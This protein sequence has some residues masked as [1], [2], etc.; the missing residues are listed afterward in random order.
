MNS[1]VSHKEHATYT[2]ELGT[3]S[4]CMRVKTTMQYICPCNKL[5]KE[6][7]PAKQLETIVKSIALKSSINYYNNSHFLGQ[8]AAYA[9]VEP[10]LK[11]SET[12]QLTVYT[13]RYSISFNTL[14]FPVGL[15]TCILDKS[16]KTTNE[17]QSLSGSHILYMPNSEST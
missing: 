9:P 15:T 17:S 5:A 6:R 12:V 11:C 1:L 3:Q 8:R 10:W 14:P 2:L 13:A 16:P 7:V 4:H